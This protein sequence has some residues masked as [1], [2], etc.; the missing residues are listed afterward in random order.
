MLKKKQQQKKIGKVR[1]W[2]QAI[3]YIGHTEQTFV[4]SGYDGL[5]KLTAWFRPI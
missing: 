5:W 4:C 1:A 3:D 2:D